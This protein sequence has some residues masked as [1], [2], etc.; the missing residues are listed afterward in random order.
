[1]LENFRVHL[2]KVLAII[3]V[4]LVIVIGLTSQIALKVI[5]IRTVIGGGLFALIGYLFGLIL[6]KEQEKAGFSQDQK[7]MITQ[8]KTDYPASSDRKASF[9]DQ[10]FRPLQAENLAK[11]VVDS[12]EE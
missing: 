6:D 4:S 5:L 12:L 7:Q 1:M 11:I 9:S 3:A 2:A 8:L 10:D